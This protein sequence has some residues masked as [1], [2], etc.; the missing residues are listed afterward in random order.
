MKR[1]FLLTLLLTLLPFVGWAENDLTFKVGGN[2]LSDGVYEYTGDFT[3]FTVDIY[4][5]ET[6]VGDFTYTYSD[7]VNEPT[8]DGGG[9]GSFLVTAPGTYEVTAEY[10]NVVWSG[11]LTVRAG[12][13]AAPTAISIKLGNA[14]KT[15]CTV[16]EFRSLKVFYGEED[17]TNS[18][19]TTWKVET[20]TPGE[21]DDFTVVVPGNY[22]ARYTPTGSDA[23][24]TANVT[25][26]ANPK[27]EVQV[28]PTT[29][30]SLTYG[31]PAAKIIVT[32]GYFSITAE[33]FLDETGLAEIASV[34]KIKNAEALSKA[35]VG[36]AKYTLILDPTA[37]DVNGKCII[38]KD[39][40]DYN[41]NPIGLQGEVEI[42]KG[43]NSLI[44]DASN[45]PLITVKTDLKYT[46]AAQVLV[47]IPTEGEGANAKPVKVATLGGVQY[48]AISVADYE[49]A[50]QDAAVAA[51]QELKGETPLTEEEIAAAKATAIA[52]MPAAGDY[53]FPEEGGVLNVTWT[54]QPEGTE[55]GEYFVW[56]KTL[57]TSNYD[58]EA[59]V[60][61]DGKAK[62]NPGD[63]TIAGTINGVA[64][65]YYLKTWGDDRCNNVY[66]KNGAQ[67]APSGTFTAS[68]NN[69]NPETVLARAW[70]VQEAQYNTD[71]TVKKDEDGNIIWQNQ[72]PVLCRAYTQKEG[73]HEVG[74]IYDYN[75]NFNFHVG[76][77]RMLVAVTG[78]DS[79]NQTN[80]N[81]G[82]V[83]EFIFEVVNPTYTVTTTPAT[84]VVSYDNQANATF[85][86]SV[87]Y[88]GY[89]PT[90]VG[91]DPDKTNQNN[92]VWYK[93]GEEATPD[94][95]GKYA[96]G[97][98]TVKIK[99]LFYAGERYWQ[100]NNFEE[101][102]FVPAQVTILAGE[103]LAKIEDQELVYGQRL[104]LYLTFDSGSGIAPTDQD[105]IDEFNSTP[106]GTGFK[107]T[108][109]K[110][111]EGNAPE[112]TVEMSLTGTVTTNNN[113]INTTLLPVGTWKVSGEF[114]D[115][116]T[117][118]ILVSS[119]TWKVTPKD[120]ANED[121]NNPGVEGMRNRDLNL[122][123]TYTS[124]PIELTAADLN[125]KFTYRDRPLE[126]GVDFE[127]T[128]YA[129][130]VNAGTATFTITGKGNFTGTRENRRFTIDKAKIY[131]FPAILEDEEGNPQ[132][133]TW[134]VGTPEV[135]AGKSIFTVDWDSETEEN[136]GNDVT[137]K[138]GIY[139]QLQN[140]EQDRKKKRDMAIENGFKDL[141]ARRTVPANA[142]YYEEGLIA[143]L[144]EGAAK[145]DNYEF[146]WC[147]GPL[148]IEKGTIKI[149]LADQETDYAFVEP[150]I[151]TKKFELAN[152][153]DLNAI[154]AENLKANLNSVIVSNLDKVNIVKDWNT[155]KQE[156]TIEGD[157]TKYYRYPVGNY[158]FTAEVS[159][160]AF[161]AT[162]YKIVVVE[163]TANLTVNPVKI[164]V[165]AEN[166]TV[167]Y[168][169]FLDKDGAFDADAKEEYIEGITEVKPANVAVNPDLKGKDQLTDVIASLSV[170]TDNE[171]VVALVNPENPNYTV[172][173]IDDMNGTLTV[174]AL[175]GIAL[176]SEAATYDA[177]EYGDPNYDAD[178][179]LI[180]TGGDLKKI[181]DYNNM[182]V[183]FVTLKLK[184]ASVDPANEAFTQW[185]AGEWHAMVLP[186]DVTVGDIASQF[187][188]A[189][190][191]VVDKE[192]TEASSK[193]NDVHFML[194]EIT[195]VIKAN[196]PFCIKSQFDFNYEETTLYFGHTDGAFGETYPIVIKYNE[197]PSV[198]ADEVRGYTFEGTYDVMVLDNTTPQY[199]F[200]GPNSQWKFYGP[201]STSK[202]TMQPYTGYVNVGTANATREVNFFFEEED[203]STTAIN[204]AE[205][206]N[207][208]KTEGLY[209]ID[210]IKV[211]GAPTQKGVY[212]QDGKKFVK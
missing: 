23:A 36:T 205:L 105:A 26:V 85:S 49:K 35:D 130:N 82:R 140:F 206:Q 28:S 208:M 87:S 52:N 15:Q 80:T 163:R 117:N 165:K 103:I 116:A 78:S 16:S 157:E 104:P 55:V 95:N 145:A 3:A 93:N 210:G 59:P 88:T 171:I 41:I 118:R 57:A 24:L 94:A 19:S 39:G 84:T 135:K 174:N 76:T 192:T 142:D 133:Q 77:Y 155:K 56:V 64:A 164:T 126:L 167:N 127:I 179:N 121:F 150:T 30:Q 8:D 34:L 81:T 68:I 143:Y 108:L 144:P 109:I 182:P 162:N 20:T 186:F 45:K 51:A 112:A 18:T 194:P 120:I 147:T 54:E 13:P 14:E 106:R 198:I 158:P 200:L 132:P 40:T 50:Y 114:G 21:Y 33:A 46:A 5:G 119:A 178:G 61:L 124:N 47:N 98:Y 9:T 69:K 129:N 139:A 190:L 4:A 212:I 195:D 100:N 161:T 1:N 72:R 172:T 169:D 74:E 146:V 138:R 154:L 125:E 152:A 184:A 37:V 113:L 160:G 32:P 7:G 60:L 136:V 102:E 92:Y 83:P 191:N 156:V 48:F 203:G 176:L 31:T 115:G 11:T 137:V 149:Q 111:A 75:N 97:E 209:R 96:A 170:N 22:Q 86:Y 134:A 53:N 202:Y 189:I 199:R 181:K 197:K 10:E 66:S 185:K 168:A 211:Q 44:R 175:P 207:M 62:I 27:V 141:A 201:S 42:T 2:A 188:Y 90:F 17:V 65:K 38:T 58:G 29:S 151:A 73:N 180:L 89:K 6:Q 173:N 183:E 204:A 70:V 107:A 128:D 25:V 177:D 43:T 99:D 153:D 101:Q 166:Q 196:T 79:Y 187:R 148:Q 12:T 131:V 91:G 110:D 122:H 67:I 193:P 159:E 71:G 63:P 123:R